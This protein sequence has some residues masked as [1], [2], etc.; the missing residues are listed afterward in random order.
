M[1]YKLILIQLIGGIVWASCY[2]LLLEHKF[3]NLDLL[4]IIYALSYNLF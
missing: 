1:K 4:G 2:S 3:N